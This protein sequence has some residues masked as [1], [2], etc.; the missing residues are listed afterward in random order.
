M[1]LGIECRGVTGS[2]ILTYRGLGDY[3]RLGNQLS[4][5]AA[6][7]G[8]ARTHDLDVR[9][10]HWDRR[11][12]FR[13]PDELFGTVPPDAIDVRSFA[14]HIPED[15]RHFLQEFA[16][17][18]DSLDLVRRWLR[19]AEPIMAAARDK[20]GDLLD[21]PAPTAVHVRRTDYVG[22]EDRHPLQPPVY[23][24]EAFARLPRG[25]T[26]IIFTDDPDWCRDALAHLRPAAVLE[27]GPDVLDLGAMALCHHHVIANSTYSFWGA[28]LAGD[29]RAVY[30]RQWLGPAFGEA[31]GI[32]R[33]PPSWIE[34]DPFAERTLRGRLRSSRRW[35]RQ[36]G[37]RA[38]RARPTR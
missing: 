29:E 6:T 9:F 4:E 36:L 7:L 32:E 33:V 21:R 1:G 31:E 20:L 8:V 5:I 26:A 11:A 14:T 24:E 35:T 2:R 3:G 19:P 15:H 25:A 18:A 37:D 38:V 13:L 22:D 23:Y 27:P 17:F 28:L 12:D 16:L 10:D 30:P 34:I